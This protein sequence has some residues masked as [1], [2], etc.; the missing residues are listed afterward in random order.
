MHSEDEGDRASL[1]EHK[2]EEEQPKGVLFTPEQLEVLLK[3]NRPDFSELVEALKGGSPKSVGFKPARP[4]N[5]DGARDRKVVDAW[6]AKMEDYLHAAKVGRHSTVELAQS[7]LKG[8]AST[9]WRT[10]RQE[11]G[12]EPKQFQGSGFKPKANFVKKGAPFKGSQPKGVR[13]VRKCPWSH[14]L[15]KQRKYRA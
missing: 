6:L 9:W 10:V 11:K 5:F 7:Y 15:K 3:M 1:E 14:N 13:Q 2:N 12:E 8:Y 4:G